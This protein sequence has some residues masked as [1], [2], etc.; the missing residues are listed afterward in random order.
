[1]MT[2][3][4]LV[5]HGW[6]IQWLQ[7]AIDNNRLSNHRMHIDKWIAVNY[8]AQCI[9]PMAFDSLNLNSPFWHHALTIAQLDWNYSI[10][11][12]NVALSSEMNLFYLYLHFYLT[13]AHKFYNCLNLN[14]SINEYIDQNLKMMLNSYQS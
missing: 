9:S 8:L 3:L 5:L 14:Q 11:M 2:W 4:T 7:I 1:M 13:I 6:S 12:P 10:H